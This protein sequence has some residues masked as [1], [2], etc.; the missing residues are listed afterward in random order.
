MLIF[1]MISGLVNFLVLLFYHGAYPTNVTWTLFFFTMGSVAIA[2]VAIEQTRSYAY[3]YAGILGIA[4]FVVLSGFLGS[5]VFTLFLLLVILY[6]SDRIVHDCTLIDDS[7]DASGQ[8][9]IDFGRDLVKSRTRVADGPGPATSTRKTHQPGRTVMWLA[10]GALPLFGLG[11]FMLRSDEAT[12][13]RA[14]FLLAVYLFASLSLL[15][16][17]SFLGLRRYLR[18]RGVDMPSNVSIGWIAGGILLVLAILFCA[19]MAPVPGQL[20]ASFELPTFLDPP[21]D[22]KASRWGWGSE[23]AQQQNEDDAKITGESPEAPPSGESMQGAKRGEA[24]SGNAKDAPA[25]NESG[26]KKSGGESGNEKGDSKQ[27]EKGDSK[28]GEKGD[29]KQGENADSKQG[30]KGDSKQG[31]SSDGN[32]SKKSDQ[33]QK[34]DNEKVDSASETNEQQKQK[35]QQQAENDAQKKEQQQAKKKQAV[36]ASQSKSESQQPTNTTTQSSL[37]QLSWLIRA[38]IMLALIIIVGVFVWLNYESLLNWWRSLFGGSSRDQASR[39]A[40]A[41]DPIDNAPPRSFASF[42][43]PIGRESDPQRAIVITFQ[44]F[45]AW[46]REQGWQRTLNETPSEFL[47]RIATALPQMSVPASQ[48]V[49]AYNRIVYGRGVANSADLHAATMIWNLMS[50]SGAT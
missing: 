18:Q 39:N 1:L 40:I 35:D 33:N 26:G 22:R 48:V 4:G 50:R 27:G 8:G 46:T 44:A 9:L 17:T 2:R 34:S 16:T 42:S 30:E 21:D 32:Q 38:L 23:A 12:W 14:K 20:L 13:N 25:G 37:P 29:S 31:E 15:V 19:Y 10:L 41:N 6:L 11:Q 5:P 45:E 36:E 24:D 7:V 3:G 49:D 43:N 28:Q 47:R